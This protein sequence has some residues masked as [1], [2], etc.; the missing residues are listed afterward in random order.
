MIIYRH[1]IREHVLP[2]FYSLGILTFIYIMQYAIKILDRVISRGLDPFIVLEIFIINLGWI[3]ALAI[4]MAILSSV[5]MAFGR[6]SADNEVLAIKSSGLNLYHLLTP[7]FV[8]SVVICVL[9]IFYNNLILPDANHRTANLWSDISRKKPAALI[10]PDVLIRDFNNYAIHVKEADGYTG[11]LKKIKIISEDSQQGPSTTVADSGRVVQTN[12]GAYMKMTLYN[13]ETHSTDKHT[14]D[15]YFISR[16]EKQVILIPNV[17]SELRRTN[18]SY[19]GDR[20]KSSQRMLKDIGGFKAAKKRQMDKYNADIDSLL[21]WIARTDS[22]TN[23]LLS[24]D[25]VR[26][27][28]DTADSTFAGWMASVEQSRAAAHAR[29]RN[30]KNVLTRTV[31]AI[32]GQKKR[33]AQYSVEVHKKFS[34]PVACIVFLLVGAPLGI[35]ARRGGLM[36]GASYS[37]FFFILYWAFL[38]KGEN[39]ADRLMISPF[40]AMWSGNILLGVCGIFLIIRMVKETTFISW[41]WLIRLWH[42]ITAS[43][44]GKTIVFVT[45]IP[46]KMLLFPLWVLKAFIG[47]IAIYII[48]LFFGYAIGLMAAVLVIYVVVDYVSQTKQFIGI[49]LGDVTLYYLYYL[50]WIAQTVSPI[51]LLLASMFTLGKLAKNSELTAIK[52]AG[53]SV[54]LVTLPLIILGLALAPLN[55]YFGE[56]V[57]PKANLER[58]QLLDSFKDIRQGASKSVRHRKEFRRNFYYFGNPNTL[59]YFQEFSIHPQRAKNVGRDVFTD[60]AIVQRVEAQR[61][62]YIDGAWHLINGT[63]RTF[64]DDSSRVSSFDTLHD[65]ILTATPEDMV[66]KLKSAEEMSYWELIEFIEKIKKRGEKITRFR[67]ILDFKIAYPFMN[68]IVILIGVSI[69]AR[70]GKGG[71]AIL[72]GLGLLLILTYWIISQF[73]L[74]FG[75]NGNISPFLGAW[76]GN[77]IFLIPGLWLFRKADK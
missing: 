40:T 63:R 24:H 60:K 72:F 52:A 29:V 9:L 65:S 64:I 25:S 14:P 11:K 30:E 75:K 26:A 67:T 6:M 22:L 77:L 51:I 57:L 47:R 20:E 16:F 71:G 5:L 53:R 43:R 13:G 33:I 17:D 32:A 58:S 56:K 49:P 69:A 2:F 44:I 68:F 23:D 10:E 54:K 76:L 21:T 1:I 35:M 59:Y 18:S 19:R 61:A 36:I 50:P 4:P 73:A 31:R 38:I 42:G 74:T 12:D 28:L 41:G 46:I 8:A 34:I 39:M 37:V 62:S 15:S 45:T 7:V 66:V 3:V 27:G 70:I 55:F 48:R